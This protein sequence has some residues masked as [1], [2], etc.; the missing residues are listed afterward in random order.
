MVRRLL[1]ITTTTKIQAGGPGSQAPAFFA[2]S[3][4]VSIAAAIAASGCRF[5]GL[6]P[7]LIFYSRIKTNCIDLD[8]IDRID[9]KRF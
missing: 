6:N 4:A 1:T 9:R 5:A 8:R 2:V 7:F 3:I